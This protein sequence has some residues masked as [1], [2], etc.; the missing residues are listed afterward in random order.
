MSN[1]TLEVENVTKDFGEEVAVKDFS[2]TVEDGQLKSLLGPSG[3]GKTTTLRCIAGLERPTSGR[4]KINGELVADPDEGVH[5]E[6][7]NRGIGMVFQSYAVWPHMTVAENVKYPLDVQKLHTKDKRED[8]VQEVLDVVGLSKYANNRA[9][10]LSG[11]QQQ[12]VA[13]ARALVTEPNILLFDEPLSNLDAKLR[14]EMRLEIKRLHEELETTILYVTHS[15]DEAMFLSDEIAIMDHG[16]LIEEGPPGSLHEEPTTF[17]SMNFMGRCNSLVGNVRSLDNETVMT[18]SK[19]GELRSTYPTADLRVGDRV[20]ICV[21]PKSC[22]FR[23]TQ[24]DPDPAENVLTGTIASRAMTQD[25]TEF[26]VDINGVEILLRSPEVIDL[27]VGDHVDVT[28][29]PSAVRIFPYDEDLEN[30]SLEEAGRGDR[31]AGADSDD[32]GDQVAASGVIE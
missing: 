29:E 30:L 24:N 10:N 25:F 17:F 32:I 27:D 3:S 8:R 1:I 12:R 11:G 19:I 2:T 4:I 26:E 16:K 5:V 15:Q 31:Q 13:I 9:T 20:F 22:S 6:P 28:F 23:A 14:R 7:E 18:E 21:R